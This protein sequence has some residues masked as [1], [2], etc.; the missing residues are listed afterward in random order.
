VKIRFGSELQSISSYLASEGLESRD[1]PFLL[2]SFTEFL[3]E[4]YR[5]NLAGRVYDFSTEIFIDPRKGFSI[6]QS[7]FQSPSVDF[8]KLDRWIRKGH[9]WQPETYNVNR[10]DVLLPFKRQEQVQLVPGFGAPEESLGHCDLRSGVFSMG[11]LAALLF[12]SAD[13]FS[14][15]DH[16]ALLNRQLHEYRWADQRF[17]ELAAN[18]ILLNPEKRI[19]LKSLVQEVKA[20]G[21]DTV[22]LEK[23]E[24]N[25]YDNVLQ[26]YKTSL[27]DF[28][29]RNQLFHF[30]ENQSHVYVPKD[31]YQLQREA[32]VFHFEGAGPSAELERL[33]R[34]RRRQQKD[35]REKGTDNLYVL[36]SFLKWKNPEDD[37]FVNSPLLLTEVVLEQKKAFEVTY[38][39][40][41]ETKELRVN[42]V[43]RIYFREHFDLE[44]PSAVPLGREHVERF[45]ADF[46]DQLLA[47]GAKDWSIESKCVLGN[48]SYRNTAIAADYDKLIRKAAPEVLN[49]ILGF[50]QGSL[51][52]EE[53]PAHLPFYERV[54]V[55]PADLSQETSLNKAR[56]GSLVIEGPPGTGKSQTIVNL[57][58]QGIAQGERVLFVSEKKPALDVV[59]SRLKEAGIGPLALL[60]HDQIKEKKACIESLQSSY[61]R[62]S[63]PL[64]RRA[65]LGKQLAGWRLQEL[66]DNLNHYYTQVREEKHGFTLN[67]LFLLSDVENESVPVENIP[68]Y[69][70]WR[71]D[72][73]IL[74]Q[75]S[76]QLEQNYGDSNWYGSPLV[77]LNESAFATCEKPESLFKQKLDD[78]SMA[79]EQMRH[80]EKKMSKDFP[81]TIGDL[82]QIRSLCKSLKWLIEK[83]LAKLVLSENPLQESYTSLKDDYLAKKALYEKRK[84]KSAEQ[85][86][87]SL[88]ELESAQDQLKSRGRTQELEV[89][90][91]EV[92][93]IDQEW[94]ADDVQAI[95]RNA[96]L[97]RKSEE[98]LVVIRSKFQSRF[99]AS[100]PDSFIE[101]VSLLQDIARRT[102]Y[103]M[104]HFFAFLEEKRF[105]DRLLQ[106]ILQIDATFSVLEESAS[107][108]H[109]SFRA[110]SLKQL[111]K[112]LSSLQAG[113]HMDAAQ[114]KLLS[115]FNG[116]G[117]SVKHCMCRADTSIEKL[118]LLAAKKE[119]NRAF[120]SY[121]D[122]E[123]YNS[124]K[125]NRTSKDISNAYDDWLEW[126][127]AF[128]LDLRVE[129]LH[130]LT[131]LAEVPAA[132][133]SDEEKQRK[134]R[135]K[136][137]LRLLKHEFDKSKQFKSLRE[138][139]STDAAAVIDE[140]KP[141]CLMSPT[142]VAEVFPCEAE[143]FDMV[144]F[145]E[146]SQIRME[147]VL[148]ICY[149]A[150]KIVVVGD[151]QQLPPSDFFRSQRIE[152]STGDGLKFSSFLMA[153]RAAFPVSELSWHYRSDSPSLIEF[154]NASFY[155]NK[156]AVFPYASQLQQ[157]FTVELV[158]DGL[159]ESRQNK[160]EA[161][162]L[163]DHLAR[164][165]QEHPER[166]FAVVTLSEA[167]QSTV[168][169][170]IE[171]LCG[172]DVAFKRAMAR[173][174]GRIENGAYNGLVVRNLENMQ[175]EER[176]IVYVSIG[177]G[178][179][180]EGKFASNFGPIMHEG[181][182]RRLNVLFSRAKKAMRL[183][184]SFKAD[185]V[186]ND[187]NIGLWTL[188]QYMR[189]AVAVQQNDAE[190]Q[191]DVL[192][193]LAGKYLRSESTQDLLS[194]EQ[195]T[196]HE[197]LTDLLDKKSILMKQVQFGNSTDLLYEVQK[198]GDRKLLLYLESEKVFTWRE[199]FVAR[200]VLEQRGYRVFQ[201]STQE[202]GRAPKNVLSQIMKELEA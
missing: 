143:R 77:H 116:L 186:K 178:F 64:E 59:Y 145:D 25:P 5:Q 7:N 133:L 140:L 42:E 6:S 66:L 129:A 174:E 67:S 132:R 104:P 111:E 51:Q 87:V 154:S 117:A 192:A 57:L 177:Y 124:Q 73:D 63:Q 21:K 127:A 113:F 55:L 85:I 139:Y 115:L 114:V 35:V 78:C 100:D 169:Q 126:N 167:Q 121:P 30:S 9:N 18:C 166:S 28:S 23:D 163:V 187:R 27:L 80:W 106:S 24:L 58:A 82:L 12:S 194:N 138:L 11:M 2:R 38:C 189:Y 75:I 135:F 62:L 144:V 136:K 29:S 164:E 185:D 94:F 76:H 102:A 108:L 193:V 16:T 180:R 31:I 112:Y 22:F 96:I 191:R 175:G 52:V 170:A 190:V 79:I 20:I 155:G 71:N 197:L 90:V 148:P 200:R 81:T 65:A 26:Q 84:S 93:S 158:K 98:Q 86:E 34:I 47:K 162:A 101:Q 157:P 17:S 156:L 99:Q 14:E 161:K 120:V 4:L 97:A 49:R 142:A 152:A 72:L 109:K 83:D 88:R 119:V 201:I 171:T 1:V 141:V 50:S 10:L 159:Y 103:H 91:R 151:N 123:K 3:D 196:V 199:T 89:F 137:G 131:L 44:L 198:E 48:F 150:R 149:R 153:C 130:E 43:L 32:F 184:V 165:M 147:D 69:S 46:E 56:L 13:V 61:E 118:G 202:L 188:K 179:N 95:L 110:L 182:E 15:E 74:T 45:Y 176:D 146:A 183:F 122:L 125:L 128:V 160:N 172:H 92:L 70:S 134:W 168:E 53:D 8:R 173:E 39:L 40:S 105:P 33:H 107:W 195:R 181:G 68:D 19:T 36:A 60:L 37:S 41:V 54:R